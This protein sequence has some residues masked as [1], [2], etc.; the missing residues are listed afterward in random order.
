MLCSGSDQTDIFIEGET[1]RLA[2]QKEIVLFRVVQEIL[3]N[4]LKHAQ[5]KYIK[6]S[7][8]FA[9]TQFSLTVQ[10]DGKGFDFD[11]VLGREMSKSVR[12]CAISNAVRRCWV[13]LE[14]LRHRWAKVLLW[15]FSCPCLL[16]KNDN[17]KGIFPVNNTVFFCFN[18]G[19]FLVSGAIGKR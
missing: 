5:A 15:R 2:G 1:Y 14:C 16:H 8:Q 9:P 6:V 3:S 4:I 13:V 12:G 17:Y 18:K 11:A 10:D 7:L 19:V